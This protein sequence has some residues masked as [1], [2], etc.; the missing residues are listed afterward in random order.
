[1]ADK[2]KIILKAVLEGNPQRQISRELKV[3]RTTVARY[4]KNYEESK[5]K[6]MESDELRI[7]ENIISPPKYN[8][9]SR[10]KV[11]LNYEIIE[12]IQSFLKENEEKRAT[13]RSKQQKKKIDILEALRDAGHDIGYTTVCNAVSD[14]ERKSREAFIRQQYNFG[15]AAEFDWGEVKLIIDKKLRI[16][17]MGVFT[18]CRGNYRYA[19]LYYSQKMENFLHLHTEFFSHVGGVYRQTIYDNLR[20]AVARFV[21]KN[22]KEPTDDLLKLSIYYNFR[23]RFCNASQAHEKGNGKYMIM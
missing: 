11:K 6:L 2:Q 5:S 10:K 21:G 3:S 4:L 17:Q 8:S 9:C 14:I 13:G 12:R 16:I 22:E 15:D 7:K 20:T 19:D 1:M 18:T 23:F